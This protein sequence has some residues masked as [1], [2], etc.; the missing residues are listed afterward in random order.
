M[1]TP[2][3]GGDFGAM[4]DGGSYQDDYIVLNGQKLLV[5]GPIQGGLVS[6]FATG[7][8]IGKAT[9]DELEHAF[10]ISLEDFSG[11]FGYRQ[12]DVR[13]AGGTHWDNEGGVDLRRAGHITLPPQRL[14]VDP[15]LDPGSGALFG[16][17]HRSIYHTDLG[18]DADGNLYIGVF[19]SIY[20]L[21]SN[22]ATLTRRYQQTGTS[23]QFSRIV[24][25]VTSAGT[26]FLLAAGN[27]ALGTHSYA[28]SLD[29]VTWTASAGLPA[30]PNAS[31]QLS[32]AIYWDSLIV[33][34]GEGGGII[35]SADGIAWDVT[36]TGALDVR[37]RTQ[38]IKVNFLGVSMAP[39]GAAAIY[40]LSLGKLW[41]LDF[42]TYNAIE[43]EDVGSGNRLGY[44][45]IWNGSVIVSDGWNV[46]EYNPGNAQTVRRIGL[47][48][49]DG[50]PTSM[51]SDDEHAGTANDYHISHFIPGTSD[52]FAVCR[53]LTAPRS[54]R[55]A[56]YNGVGWSWLGTE[57]G[58]TS[59]FT[60]QP[61]SALLDFFP[62]S[63]SLTVGT[64]AIDVAT[65]NDQSGTD[66]TL[67]T[68]QL[69]SSGDTPFYG[70]GQRF[71]DGPLSF[72]TG[73]FDGGFR[74]LEGALFRIAIDGYHISNS[75]TVLVEYRLDN[76]ETESAYITLGTFTL[77][78]QKIWFD[79]RHEGVAFKTVQFRISLDRGGV[80]NRTPE[81]RA[82]VLLYD[83]IVPIRTS[84]N[85]TL[86][87]AKMVENH[88]QIGGEEASTENIWQFLKSVVRTPTLAKME[89]P[90]LESGGVYVR[91]TDMPS[92][93]DDI[94]PQRGGRGTLNLQLIEPAT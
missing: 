39:W 41:V 56:V 76:V 72:E 59:A 86:D 40:Y 66:F 47:Y 16:G 29:G 46:W 90:S 68:I 27:S 70:G 71:Q 3:S 26:R 15:N 80:L 33:A 75:E 94:R 14:S 73:W 43:I 44:G 36:S 65:L 58:G 23:M 7:L 12:L 79:D 31:V 69:P 1:P 5:K 64:R 55:L 10:W 4:A 21:S 83:K 2:F 89:I 35:A 30:T 78:Q 17:G 67:F 57:V 52:L 53:S 25:G 24:E 93:L 13:E 91:I 8:K 37:W 45:C 48:G 18:P 22:R 61:Y 87:L 34:H 84:W 85:I 32:D 54:W 50:P 81:L 82:L 19:D 38:D 51:I 60:S 92:S 28:R 62:T 6:Q 88:L 9:Y 20:T 63:V 77:N 11:G 49:K 74:E 42:Y